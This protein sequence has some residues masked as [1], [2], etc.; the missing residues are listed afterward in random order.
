[1]KD[2]PDFSLP[3]QTGKLRTLKEFAGKWALL[4]FY[5]KDNTPGCTKEACDFR[6]HGARFTEAGIQILGCSRDSIESHAEFAEKHH[7]RFPL[8]SDSSNSTHLAYGAWIEKGFLGKPSVLRN[9]YLIDP[10]GL[11]VKEYHKVN[12][13]T[14]ANQILKDFANIQS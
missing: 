7:L 2:A 3:D 10:K 5:P 14:H 12:P 8:L 9:S 1:M 11:I 6:D 4:Y 13:L